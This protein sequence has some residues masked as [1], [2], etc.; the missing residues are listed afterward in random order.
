MPQINAARDRRSQGDAE[1]KSRFSRLHGLSVALNLLQLIAA[2][3]I[4]Y[5]FLWGS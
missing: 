3:Y 2:G 4:L 5:R 1:A